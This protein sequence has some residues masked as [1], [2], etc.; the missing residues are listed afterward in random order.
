[1]S[2]TKT[3]ILLVGPKGSGKTYLASRMESELGIGFVRVEPIWLEL[4]REVAPGSEHF[5]NE[6]QARVIAQV[7]KALADHPA[8]VLESTGAAPWFSRQ[9]SDLEALGDLVLIKVEVPLNLCSNRIHQR[10]AS[11]HIAVSDDRIAE[12][13]AVAKQVE[14]PWTV[15]VQNVDQK[16][17]DEFINTLHITI[18]LET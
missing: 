12:I 16:Q 15:V 7:K 4:S 3:I 1:M 17:A 13:N 8:V 11:Q 2:K 14:L 5:D 9:M 6:G 10:D 18:G